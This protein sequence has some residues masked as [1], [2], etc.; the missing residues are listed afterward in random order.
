MTTETKNIETVQALYAAY[1]RGDLQGVLEL[2]DEDVTW[3]IDSVAAGEV[4]P[5]GIARGKSG[6]A[7]FFAAWADNAEFHS[8]TP[9]E[10]IAAGDHVF[11]HLKY[12]GV[13]KAT[14]KVIQNF[15]IQHWTLK[16]GKIV[17][18]RGYEDTA[19]TRDAFRR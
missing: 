6:V 12:H 15:S 9:H 13:V 18:W 8:F 10:Y 3:G 19:A 14:G 1:G 2:L 11:N 5:Y 17:R 7:K 4:A 16:N